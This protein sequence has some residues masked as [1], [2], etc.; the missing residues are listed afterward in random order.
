MQNLVDCSIQ[1]DLMLHIGNSLSS[2]A[3]NVS[4]A[5]MMTS[6]IKATKFSHLR[7]RRSGLHLMTYHLTPNHL[8]P[9]HFLLTFQFLLLLPHPLWLQKEMIEVNP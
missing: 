4:L 5:W 6:M 7:F 9:S 8:I 3:M 2:Q 1:V